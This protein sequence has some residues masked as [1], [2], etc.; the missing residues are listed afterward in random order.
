MA[1]TTVDL[2][3]MNTQQLLAFIAAQEKEKAELKAKNEALAKA[4]SEQGSY[5]V[6]I[7]R[8]GTVSVS[9]FGRY[10]LSHYKE[11]WRTLAKLIPAILTFIDQNEQA[12]DERVTT[13]VGENDPNPSKSFKLSM[14]A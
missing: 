4:A 5:S 12:I 6:K 10:P 11:Q 2:S 13:P 7:G 8:S 1:T 3:K 14:A 9:G